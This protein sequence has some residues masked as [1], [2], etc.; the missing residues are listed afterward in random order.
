MHSGSPDLSK[1]PVLAIV[2]PCFNEQDALPATIDRL[3][4]ELALM[5]EDRLIS[6]ESF[7][8]FVDDGSSDLTW[9]VLRAACVEIGHLAALR[10]SRNFGHQNA[11]LAGLMSVKGRC[12]ISISIDADL[13]QDPLAMRDFIVQYK[14]GAHVVF[15]VRRDRSS[16]GRFKKATALSFYR[17]MNAMGVNTIPNH[18]DYRLLSRRALEILSMYM[19]PNLFLRAICVQFGFKSAVVEFDVVERIAG[20]SKYSL[21]KML[22]L[23][24]NGITSFSVAPLRLIA[25][26]GTVIFGASG[27]MGGYILFRSLVVGDT[28]PGWASITLPIYFLGGVQ[29][30]CLCVIGEYIAQVLTS[31]KNRPRYIVEE[32]VF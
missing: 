1:S 10:L 4:T 3:S 19:E 8:Y 25:V 28:V 16:D 14:A 26:L 11:L 30:L 7:L 9:S 23:A 17:L 21:S 13:Q 6:N 20:K 12:D 29:I 22:K 27:L 24:I 18:A 5:V 15:G 31:V 2:V 32:E